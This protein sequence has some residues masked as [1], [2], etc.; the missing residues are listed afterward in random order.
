MKLLGNCLSVY[1]HLLNGETYGPRVNFIRF[2]SRKVMCLEPKPQVFSP[3]PLLDLVQ[4]VGAKHFVQ[5]HV[6]AEVVEKCILCASLVFWHHCNDDCVTNRDPV[7][8]LC[9][10]CFL[11]GSH[12]R[13]LIGTCDQREGLVP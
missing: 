9:N 1:M 12:R 5:G 8:Q 11:R 4:G 6:K 7:N 13:P 3:H 10:K 2:A